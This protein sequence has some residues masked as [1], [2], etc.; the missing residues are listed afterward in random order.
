[1]EGERKRWGWKQNKQKKQ[2][3]FLYGPKSF[4]EFLWLGHIITLATRS[5]VL[6]NGA[7]AAG[8][9]VLLTYA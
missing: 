9:D 6:V 8:F 4:H 5:D 7:S 2:A 3:V 1:M